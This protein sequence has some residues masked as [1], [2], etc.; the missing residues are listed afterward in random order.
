MKKMYLKC[1]ILG[2]SISS[3]ESFRSVILRGYKKQYREMQ[4]EKARFHY[5]NSFGK[6][7]LYYSLYLIYFWVFCDFFFFLDKSKNDQLCHE[8]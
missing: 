4:R 5:L 2:I 1:E 7:T 3:T 6:D 8:S